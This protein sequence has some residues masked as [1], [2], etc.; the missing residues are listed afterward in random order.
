M[1][2]PSHIFLTEDRTFIPLLATNIGEELVD[3]SFRYG[4]TR[5][6]ELKRVRATVGGKTAAVV[7]ALTLFAFVAESQLTQY[8]QT[9]LGFRQPFFLFYIAHSSFCVIFPVHLLCLVAINGNTADAYISGLTAALQNQLS[10]KNNGSPLIRDSAFPYTKLVLLVSWLTAGVT[11]PS[12]LWFVAITLASVSDVTALW[13][14]NAF[15]AYVIHVKLS[16]LHWESRKLASVVIASLGVLVVVYGSESQTPPEA[17]SDLAAARRMITQPKAPLIG[18]ILTL[19]ASVGYG[20]Y[21]VMYK[22][23][24]AL[25]SDPEADASSWERLS[26]SSYESLSDTLRPPDDPEQL[27]SALAFPPPFGLHSNFLTSCI[28]LCTLC[29]L[30][31]PIPLLHHADIETFKLPSNWATFF[32]VCGI[33]LTGVMF[34]AGFMILLG[35]WGPIITSVGNLLTIVLVLISDVVLWGASA[36]LT[37]WSLLGSGMIVCAFAVLVYDMFY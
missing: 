35:V 30:W 16:R 36:V 8:V 31:I 26:V 10:G 17:G 1:L 2:H 23:H 4:W 6:N 19:I 11:V 13:N 33:G 9:T 28:G 34:N 32:T 27:Q 3:A 20:L 5:E 12:L 14:S 15:W 7:F 22:R 24:A 25:P 29:V 37:V 18:N 21:Q